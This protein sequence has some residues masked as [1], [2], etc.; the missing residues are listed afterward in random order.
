M[1]IARQP[2]VLLVP[3]VGNSCRQEVLGSTWGWSRTLPSH[4][5]EIV[6]VSGWRALRVLE[7]END[8]WDLVTWEMYFDSIGLFLVNFDELWLVVLKHRLVHL[9]LCSYFRV[10]S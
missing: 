9:M 4:Q 6:L 3:V 2:M 7:S 5:P 10:L 1:K 8:W